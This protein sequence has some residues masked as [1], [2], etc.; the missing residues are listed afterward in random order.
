MAAAVADFRPVI[1]AGQKIKKGTALPRLEL[2]H[3]PDILAAVAQNKL[4]SGW[5]R[6]TVG[7]AAETQDLLDNAQAKLIAKKL[8]MIVANDVSAAD[9]GFGVDCNRVTILFADGRRESLPLMEKLEVAQAVFDHLLEH[10][11]RLKDG[12]PEQ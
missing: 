7:F 12:Q 1:A 6:L 9:A 2:E 3:T 5:P 10:L 4:S 11:A 8:D